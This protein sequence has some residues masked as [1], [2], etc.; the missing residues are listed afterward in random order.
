MAESL[1]IPEVNRV[2]LIGRITKDLELRYTQSNQAVVSFNIAMT[3][4]YKDQ[5]TS[6]WKELVSFIPIV[7]WGKLAESIS[8]RV[9][10]GTAVCVDGRLQSRSYETSKGE[11][12]TLVEVVADRIQVM[13]KQDKQV[14]NSEEQNQNLKKDSNWDVEENINEEDIPF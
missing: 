4:V 6:E 2:M 12:R 13:S 9:K 3:R 14:E 5:Q 11:K 10:K 8:T 7:L 1:R